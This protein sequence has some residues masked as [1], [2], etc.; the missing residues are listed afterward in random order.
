M[1]IVIPMPPKPKERPY[2]SNG[3]A[4][5]R[6]STRNYE[7]AVRYIARSRIKSVLT[8]ATKLT[9]YFYMPIPKSWS[10]AKKEEART[11]RIRPTFRPDIDNLE[12]A[13]MDALNDGIG[14]NDDSLVVEKHSYE[15]YSD[16]P[17][18]EIELEE[19]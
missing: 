15:Y 12:K 11:G 8:S 9:V 19:I 10:K 3:H 16:N 2:F 6:E 5:T 13:I 14:Y 4:F 18:T 7:D 1:K 17:R